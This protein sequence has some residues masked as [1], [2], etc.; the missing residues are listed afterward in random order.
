MKIN[1]LND[2]MK[3]LLSILVLSFLFSGSAIAEEKK[4]KASDKIIN[5][6]FKNKTVADIIELAPTSLQ[7][8]TSNEG[9]VQYH[10]FVS[11]KETSAKVPVICFVNSKSTVCRVP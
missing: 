7:E 10:F 3:K 5:D 4:I 8:I 9:G 6:F 1:S 2:F 11:M